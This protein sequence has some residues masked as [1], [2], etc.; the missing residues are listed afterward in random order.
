M[1]FAVWV[2]GLPGSGKSTIAKELIK[3]LKNT[4][5]LRLDEIRKRYIN[6]PKFNDEERELVYSKF[7]DE[8]ISRIHEGKNVVFDATA[9]KLQWRSQ[10]RSRIKNFIEVNVKCPLD[11]CVERESKRGEGLVLANLYRKAL[12][13]KSSGKM[14]EGLGQVV[15]VDVPF[16]ENGNV[17]IEIESEKIG[18]KEAASAIFNEIKKRGWI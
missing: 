6:E 11:V 3:K 12:E 17:E 5:Y 7:I 1:P 4:E 2:T 9:H 18:P 15:G 13:R 10:A 16:E 14:F 8:G